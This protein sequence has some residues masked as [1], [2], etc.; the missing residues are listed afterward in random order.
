MHLPCCDG[1]GLTL[2]RNIIPQPRPVML[3]Y[4]RV[5]ATYRNPCKLDLSGVDQNVIMRRETLLYDPYLVDADGTLFPV[6]VLIR[7][8]RLDGSFSADAA[9]NTGPDPEARQYVRRFAFIDRDSAI[10]AGKTPLAV[11]VASS[12]TLQIEL[13]GEGAGLFYPPQLIVT[14]S[15]VPYPFVA[16]T[17]LDVI[18]ETLYTQD[19]SSY[20]KDI[21]IAMCVFAVVAAIGAFVRVQA[22]RRRNNLQH[23]DFATLFQCVCKSFSRRVGGLR[24]PEDSLCE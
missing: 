11:R 19:L 1:S 16:G 10:T 4:L 8:Y 9:V 13:R 6:P 15:E 7:N 21:T 23:L 18:F 12:V 5:G 24:E 17:E 14:Y 3:S 20:R 22:Y 2:P